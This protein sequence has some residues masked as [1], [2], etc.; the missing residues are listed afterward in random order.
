M[1]L[2]VTNLIKWKL[3]YLKQLK[4]NLQTKDL[5]HELDN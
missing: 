5:E 1:N 3:V 2:I 4:N